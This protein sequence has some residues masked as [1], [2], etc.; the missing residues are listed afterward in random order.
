MERWPEQVVALLSIFNAGGAYVP[1]E[2]AYPREQLDFMLA[3]SHVPI[4]LEDAQKLAAK[5]KATRLEGCGR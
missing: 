4:L 5:P 1:L 2:P 3:D